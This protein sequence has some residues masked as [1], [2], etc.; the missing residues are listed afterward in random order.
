MFLQTGILLSARE[1]FVHFAFSLHFD[2]RVVEEERARSIYNIGG[3]LR[4]P[5]AAVPSA[6]RSKAFI[7]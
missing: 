3:V 5:P 7:S 6:R 1:L 2:F 4:L